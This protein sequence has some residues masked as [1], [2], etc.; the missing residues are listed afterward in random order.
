MA[1]AL[2]HV[3]ADAAIIVPPYMEQIAQTPALLDFVT[4]NLDIIAYG[5]GDISQAAG[6]TITSKTRLFNFNGSTETGLYPL[7]RPSG[8]FPAEDWKYIHP[9]PAAGLEF[10]PRSEGVYEAYI[11]RNSDFE[12]EQPVFKIFPDLQE[13]ATK[14]LFTPHPSKPD[15]WTYH[16]RADDIIVF[17]TA[18]QSNPAVMEQHVSRHPLVTAAIMIGTGRF[19]PAL[20]IELAKPSLTSSEETETAESIIEQLWPTIE[21]TNE[22]YQLDARVRKSHIIFTDPGKPMQ[23]AGKGTVQRVLTL[24]LYRG[25]ID[26]LYA[27]AGDSL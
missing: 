1:D 5:G 14:D 22:T 12:H 8:S 6:D 18:S 11:I 10:R 27:K 2:K 21:T 25:E 3:K 13:F 24:E 17:K 26:A 19:Q 20:L 4:S 15:L 7:L 9:H 16:G 23:R